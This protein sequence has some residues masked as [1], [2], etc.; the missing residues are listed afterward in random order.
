MIGVLAELDG[1]LRQR[2]SARREVVLFSES[3]AP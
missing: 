1:G 2:P 3:V